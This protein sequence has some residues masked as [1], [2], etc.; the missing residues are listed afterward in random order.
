MRSEPS[1]A[2]AL[3]PAAEKSAETPSSLRQIEAQDDNRSGITRDDRAP[4][5]G[6]VM[7]IVRCNLQLLG[8]NVQTIYAWSPEGFG[9]IHLER[10]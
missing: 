1:L 4:S 7:C 9:A 2:R 6:V 5:A 8:T 10:S 3:S